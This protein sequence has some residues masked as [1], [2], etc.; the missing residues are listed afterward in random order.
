M[1]WVF[2]NNLPIYLQIVNYLSMEI[3]SGK[4]QPGEKL[5]SVRDLASQAS[6]NPNTVQKALAE[7]GR[8]ELCYTERTSGRYVTCNVEV[9]AS[10]RS[11]L[12][13]MYTKDYLDRM[14]MIGYCDEDIVGIIGNTRNNTEE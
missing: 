2:D 11:R 7:L 8:Y 14:H 6:V 3:A 9:I 5:P 1:R 4:I 10:A 13:D 12:A